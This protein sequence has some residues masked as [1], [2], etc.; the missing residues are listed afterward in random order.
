MM[1]CGLDLSLT[2]SAIVCVPT[3]WDG[4]WKRVRSHVVGQSL[5]RSANDHERVRRCESIAKT[6]TQY[7]RSRG[8]SEAWFESYAYGLRT[9]AHS[10]GEL[11]GIVRLVM[12]QSN[13]AL[14]T[15]N[16][17]TAR[18]LLLGKVPRKDAKGACHE[19]LLEAGRPAW[20]KD[21]TDAFVAA[22]LGLSEH[23]G[24]YCFASEA[25]A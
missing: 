17:S 16:M 13:I 10:L 9:S 25:R 23:P 15:A 1:I 20:S 21:E 5:P 11:G 4:D 18:K 2:A 6:L 8:V 19:A 3:D 22:N 12:D 14:R 24:A 7:A